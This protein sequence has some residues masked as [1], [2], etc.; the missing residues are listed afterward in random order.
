MP[1]VDAFDIS[2]DHK[3]ELLKSVWRIA[4]NFVDRAYGIDST[5]ISVENR[6]ADSGKKCPDSVYLKAPQENKTNLQ[7]GPR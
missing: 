4:Q 3:R 2:D 7:G 1:L 6:D 5:Q